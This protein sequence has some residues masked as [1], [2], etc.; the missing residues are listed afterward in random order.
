MSL[1]T[2]GDIVGKAAENRYAIPAINCQG[3]NYDL[4]RAIVETAH[5]E[6]A[7]IIVASH[8]NN[9]Q[10]YGLDWAP[11][12]VS[13]LLRT[14][15]VPV[16][17]HLDHGQDIE[18]VERATT[19]GYTSVMIDY[20]TKSLEENVAA[21]QRV[22]KVAH[23]RNISVEAELGELQRNEGDTE[24]TPSAAENLVD[25]A[26]VQEFLAQAPVDMLAVGIG[27]AHGFYKG[28]PNIRVDLVSEVRKVSGATPLV[29]HGTTGIPEDVVKECIANGMAKI[30]FGTMIR[31]N[32]MEYVKEALD[33]AL[34]HKGHIWRVMHYAMKKVKEDVRYIIKLTGSAGKA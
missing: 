14:Y 24:T 16:A 1:V 27:N 8:P 25:P 33:G 13:H 4:V 22:L 5:E 32:F 26:H 18:V 19:L 10:Y 23:K 6:R 3:G 28:E 15:A 2:S 34:E 12:V 21:A 29:L 11:F 30:N 7:P 31:V 20:S 9:T 17:V